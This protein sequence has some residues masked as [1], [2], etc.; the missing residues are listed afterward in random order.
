MNRFRQTELGYKYD[1]VIFISTFSLFLIL[2]F[3][4]FYI[5]HFD[6]GLHPYFECNQDFCKNP[7]STLK[8]CQQTLKVLWLIPLYT[9]PDC[10]LNCDWCSAETLSRGVYGTRPR[11]EFIINN[12]AL[13]GFLFIALALILNHLLHNKGKQFDIEIPIT[14]KIRINRNSLKKWFKDNEKGNNNL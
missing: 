13:I 5:N 4:V 2:I 11:G 12:A 14:E 10:K 3:Y 6:F 1:K 7:Y 8:D 9:T